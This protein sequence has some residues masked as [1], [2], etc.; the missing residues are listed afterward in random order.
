VLQGRAKRF[1]RIGGEE[2]AH[3]ASPD[4]VAVPEPCQGERVVLMTTD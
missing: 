1:A 4:A 2:L 3:R